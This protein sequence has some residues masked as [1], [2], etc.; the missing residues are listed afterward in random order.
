MSRENATTGL[1]EATRIALLEIAEILEPYTEAVIVG[2]TVPFLLVPQTV[3][4]HEGTVDIDIVLAL[5]QRGANDVYTLHETLERRLFTQNTRKPFRYTK[6]ISIDGEVFEVLIELLG[7]GD[8]PPGGLHRIETEDVRV[9]IIKGM[10][11]AL[12]NPRLVS[13]PD[14]K[15]VV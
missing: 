6:S 12:E 9:S 13:L 3:E 14:R 10:E 1:V 2:G 7:G 15:S 8:P 5:D 4:A 11:V